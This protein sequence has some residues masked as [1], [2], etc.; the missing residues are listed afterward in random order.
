MQFSVREEPWSICR[1]SFLCKVTVDTKMIL[2]EQTA[3]SK[4]SQADK[5][6]TSI[7]R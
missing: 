1:V 4:H 2:Q 7:D 5:H 6:N 3:D